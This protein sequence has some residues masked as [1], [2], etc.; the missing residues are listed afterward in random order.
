MTNSSILLNFG[1]CV[2]SI[3]FC[4]MSAYSPA[5]SS[6]SIVIQQIDLGTRL[7]RSLPSPLV[8][9]TTSRIDVELV[10]NVL[11]FF[12]ACNISIIG[13][14][15]INFCLVGGGYTAAWSHFLL[16]MQHCKCYISLE[17]NSTILVYLDTILFL[18]LN[19]EFINLTISFFLMSFI[20][21]SFT[22]LWSVS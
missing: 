17:H 1:F 7:G 16:L 20:N 18:H 21:E 12:H 5:H 14:G 4:K 11:W 3:N 13:N 19:S 10:K 9:Q 15:K 8:N 2:T 22:C 6:L